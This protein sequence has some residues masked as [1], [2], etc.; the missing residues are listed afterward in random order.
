MI[1]KS[2]LNFT[3]A[4]MDSLEGEMDK[5]SIKEL[6]IEPYTKD[7]EL[8]KKY[9][10]G[11]KLDKKKVG[12]THLEILKGGIYFFWW[13][14]EDESQDP[15]KKKLGERGFNFKG[16][17]LKGPVQGDG[18]THEEIVVKLTEEWIEKYNGL[19]PLYVGKSSESMFTRIS[20]HLQITH[21]DFR[22]KNTSNQLRRGINELFSGEK[23]IVELMV[24][25][26][27]FSY[28]P[29]HGP[30]NAVDR[31]YLENY[32]IGKLRPI[33]NLDVER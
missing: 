18:S 15:L 24:N 9:P 16:R 4:K 19:I 33:L 14:P 23:D 17:K 7:K 21:P 13:Q 30:E 8:Y 10:T 12:D 1:F 28:I 25:N 5:R 29:L 3:Q 20:Q 31:F 6:L 22:K 26:I 32:F 11:W 2:T 27:H